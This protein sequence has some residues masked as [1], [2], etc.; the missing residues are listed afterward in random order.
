MY[1]LSKNP[2]D[3]LEDT[4]LKRIR[5][6]WTIPD[7]NDEKAVHEHV[8]DL[9]DVCEDF[10]SE[11][12]QVQRDNSLLY[13]GIH[14]LATDRHLNRGLDKVNTSARR[15]P[16]VVINH[17]YDYVEQWVS[18]F[19]RYRP[20]VAIYPTTA[21]VADKDD[22]KI[23]NNVLEHIW[24]QN[25]ID[26]VLQEWCRQVK[27]F[28]EAF[29]WVLWDPNR[30]DLH[31]DWAYAAKQGL[32][33]PVLDS[34]GN[35]ILS[36]E[37]GDPLFIQKA[38]RIGDICYKTPVPWRVFE[39]PCRDRENIDWAI[40][41]ETVDIDYLKAKYPDKA[42]RIAPDD[43]PDIFKTEKFKLS[44]AKNEVVV[45]TLFHRHHEFLD[46]GRFIK[47]IRGNGVVLENTDL[48]YSH[49]KL[50]YLHMSDIDV[51]DQTR[52]M[53]FFQQLYPIQHQINACASLI[54]KALVLFAHPKIV[55]PQNSV[56]VSQLLNESTAVFYSGNVAPSMMSQNA[57]APE[58]FSYLAKLEEL[59]D[60]ISG[61]FTMSR[62]TA[63]SGVR[64]AKALR[65]LEEQEDKRSYISV[66]KYNE[67]GIVGNAKLTLATAGDFYNDN[68][69]RLIRIV[70]KD[71]E[72]RIKQFSKAN[73][74]KPYDIRIENGT[75]L[76]KSASARIE[77]ISEI[78]AIPVT[79]DSIFSKG[80]IVTA[81]D[82]T[83]AEEFKDVAS[84]A[85]RC[86]A[87]ENEDAL[88][89]IA[90]AD[91]ATTE[92]LITHW[93]THLQPMQ[94]RDYK[95]IIPP[96]RR[97]ILEQHLRLTEF[98]M[99]QKAYGVTTPLGQMMA[100]PNPTFAMKLQALCPDFP[101]LLNTPLPPPMPLSPMP[102]GATPPAGLG[103][104]MG[105]TLQPEPLQ[106]GADTA[107]PPSALT[108]GSLM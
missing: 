76:S 37:G 8:V 1:R 77:E 38:V 69:G 87:S 11:Y 34:Q 106:N 10:Y 67:T 95:T 44:K 13:K 14:W 70:G 90:I 66:I 5:P 104:A 40:L 79:P 103:S 27:I 73:L 55:A 75:A 62:G 93:Q 60:K 101:M 9:V 84:R 4:T 19:T 89:G 81:L 24:Y 47:F 2:F 53:S 105:N 98:L 74:S 26:R 57:I 100:P 102:G 86:A 15:S 31:P 59:A 29:L 71:N 49:G 42:E 58:L 25:N 46:K 6:V 20:A 35:P 12:F 63:P 33:V 52:G 64:A 96:E 28:G 43:S 39:Q 48:P 23:S 97:A 45:Y 108:P 72:Y 16:R 85:Y 82:L 92:D 83:A 18:R 94:S 68:D 30:G 21:D 32:R 91:P 78:N 3:D 65:A 56:E 88:A 7:F 41:W 51:P 80:Q 99:F 22:A 61:I 17:L 107:L 50:P 36:E 54:Y